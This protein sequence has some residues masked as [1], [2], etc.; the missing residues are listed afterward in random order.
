MCYDGAAVA[1]AVVVVAV[2]GEF[3]GAIVAGLADSV[4]VTAVLDDG[5][6]LAL[7]DLN[8]FDRDVALDVIGCRAVVV[9]AADDDDDGGG[10]GGDG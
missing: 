6:S 5:E 9:V 1:A 4:D 3:D 8:Y 7:I 10:D 2:D